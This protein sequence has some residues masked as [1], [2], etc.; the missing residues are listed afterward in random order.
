SYWGTIKALA[1]SIEAKDI[2]TC[3][4]SERVVG[5][6]VLIGKEMGLSSKEIEMLKF[7]SILH[8]IGKIAINDNIL[9]KRSPLR[10]EEHQIIKKHPVKG[11]EIIAP[12]KFL[13]QIKPIIRHHHERW[14]GRGY[15]DGL[16][17]TS[18]PL[19][20]RIIQIADTFDAITSSRSYRL[21]KSIDDGISEIQRCAG[22]QFDPTIVYYFIR[23]YR[24][25]GLKS[26]FEYSVG[27]Y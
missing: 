11:E 21:A 9:K 26:C 25:G 10:Q 22:S 23:S 18:I 2:Y 14:D 12:L 3:G 19:F 7:S 15:P 1:H 6:S 4:H 17:K 16:V 5:Y 8:D 24:K 13:E 27:I 20:S